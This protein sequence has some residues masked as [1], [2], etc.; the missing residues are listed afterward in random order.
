MFYFR[1]CGVPPMICYINR[2]LILEQALCSLIHEYFDTLHFENK[3]RNFHISVTT[4]HPFA[5]LYLHKNLNASDRFPCVVISTMDDRKPPDFSDLAVEEAEWIG[6][7]AEDIEEAVKSTETYTDKKGHTRTREIPGVCVVKDDIALAEVN[8]VIRQQEVCYGTLLRMRREDWI[9]VEIWS[10]NNQLKNEIYEQLRLFIAGNLLHVLEK[11]YKAFDPDLR[12]E[13]V[14]GDR[15][16]NYNF[17]FD[18]I[19]YGANITFK[20]VY[21]VEQ[22]VLDTEARLVDGEIIAE[23]INHVKE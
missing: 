6:F 11:R 10:E 23:A 18:V 14:H 5:E 17:D 13:D 22:L 21:R 1:S 4:E 19:L 7:E 9:A 8:K 20:I 15:G 12:E 3:Y 2:G 16:N